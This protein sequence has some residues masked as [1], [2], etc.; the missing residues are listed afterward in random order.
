MEDHIRRVEY[1]YVTVADKPGEGTKV[2]SVLREAGV[3]LLGFSGFPAARRAQL[4]FLPADPQAFRQVAKKAKWKLVGPKKAFLIQGQDR[5]G[6]AA[7][8]HA[9]LAAAKINVKAFQAV[10]GCEE[11][12]GALLWVA[13]KDYNK[14]AKILGAA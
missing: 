3:N 10:V 12:F 6:V 2:L 4:D 8:I 1:F 11:C 7:E 5:V 14:A 9:Q 13:P